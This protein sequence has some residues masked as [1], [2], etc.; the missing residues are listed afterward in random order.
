MTDPTK[1]VAPVAWQEL[2]D[3]D[4]KRAFNTLPDMLDGF[5][6][7]WGWL[8]FAKAIEA[9]CRK[10]NE[11]AIKERDHWKTVASGKTCYVPPE[12]QAHLDAVIAERDAAVD[13]F[14]WYFGSHDKTAFIN[15]YMQGMREG[16]SLDQWRA[17]IDAAME[18]QK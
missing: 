11:A 5:L 7:T 10:K 12:F 9:E 13:R 1:P 4:R 2:T 17:A 18:K 16:W 3:E 6:K 8:H 15:T 14:D